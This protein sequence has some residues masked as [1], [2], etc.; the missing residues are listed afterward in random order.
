MDISKIYIFFVNMDL[1]Q[2]SLLDLSL[3]ILNFTQNSTYGLHMI[4]SL[5]IVDKYPYQ[6]YRCYNLDGSYY[7]RPHF[8][9]QKKPEY[10]HFV[11]I[12][13]IPIDT[14]SYYRNMAPRIDGA[15]NRFKRMYPKI[16]E[17]IKQHNINL[18]GR[19]SITI[20]GD[21]F[22]QILIEGSRQKLNK[23]LDV[24]GVYLWERK[25]F[26]ND[27]RASDDLG[28]FFPDDINH[29]EIIREF[30]PHAVPNFIWHHRTKIRDYIH[31]PYSFD[32]LR[33]IMYFR[34]LEDC[35]MAKLIA[36]S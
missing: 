35:V 27:N 6:K 23:F 20:N 5:Y 7:Y 29:Q 17:N 3:Q 2:V 11:H 14:D 34:D 24:H 18:R 26:L 13:S 32:F 19:G 4:N 12:V 31:G 15:L 8:Y 25:F 10:S 28:I 9:S 36:L 33:S 30:C 21:T 1:G 16:I 22:V